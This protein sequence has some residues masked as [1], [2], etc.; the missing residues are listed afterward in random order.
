MHNVCLAC[1]KEITLVRVTG[2][3]ITEVRG[4][5]IEHDD[6]YYQCPL[7]QE[8]AW[9]PSLPDPL[10]AAYDVYRTRHGLLTPEQVHDFRRSLGLT[11]QELGLLIGVSYVTL[12]RYERGALQDQKHNDLLKR[13]IDDPAWLSDRLS[14]VAGKLPEAKSEAIAQACR[15]R[16][17]SA[18]VAST[19]WELWELD[20]P[21]ILN[22]FKSFQTDKYINAVLFFCSATA[23]VGKTKLNKL[24]FYLDFGMYRKYGTSVTGLTFVREQYGP[25]VRHQY[26]GVEAL[27]RDQYLT[28]VVKTAGDIEY[29]TFIASVEPNI[30][31][32]SDAERDMM[33][34]VCDKFGTVSAK[35][36]SDLSHQEKAWTDVAQG[37]SIPYSFAADLKAL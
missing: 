13:A 5:K 24:L 8:K 15:I 4:E 17:R 26:S 20:P 35:K 37:S 19:P 1:E 11:Q 36:L 12:S 27:L 30:N 28:E 9:D 21:S 3:R 6:C 31:V 22:G 16:L 14:H 7:C 2:R 32:F 23:S 33:Q 34:G 25:V 29:E 18:T 10:I